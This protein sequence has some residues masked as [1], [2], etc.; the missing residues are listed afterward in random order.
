[1]SKRIWRAVRS[2]AVALIVLVIFGLTTGAKPV[3]ARGQLDCG[4]GNYAQSVG[5]I[6][7]V[8]QC[9]PKPLRLPPRVDVEMPQVV[10]TRDEVGLY[11]TRVQVRVFDIDYVQGTHHWL[12]FG[13]PFS[14]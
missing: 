10:M 7:G 8:Y 14:D 11:L 6:D 2:V 1:M 9:R 4:L 5:I 13:V 12:A 3:F